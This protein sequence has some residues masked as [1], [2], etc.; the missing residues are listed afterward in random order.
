M[1]KSIKAAGKSTF[2]YSRW[3]LFKNRHHHKKN[4]HHHQIYIQVKILLEHMVMELLNSKVIVNYNLYNVLKI[5][6]KSI[7]DFCKKKGER[8]LA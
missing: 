8:K 3:S 2:L 7:S 1:S 5:I 4:N 6:V